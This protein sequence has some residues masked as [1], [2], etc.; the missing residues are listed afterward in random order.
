MMTLGRP[1][2]G[3]NNGRIVQI[4]LSTVIWSLDF[5]WVPRV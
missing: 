5:D 4:W 1:E 2:T 3:Y